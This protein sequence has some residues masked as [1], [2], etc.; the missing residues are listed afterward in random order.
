MTDKLHSP[1]GMEYLVG[2]RDNMDNNNNNSSSNQI[3]M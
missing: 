2:S 3:R 1:N